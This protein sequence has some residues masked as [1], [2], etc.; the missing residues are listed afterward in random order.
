M[1]PPIRISPN[2]GEESEA[3][4]RTANQSNGP[5]GHQ[6]SLQASNRHPRQHQT[7]HEVAPRVYEMVR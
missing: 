2:K 7:Q 4:W 6:A 1:P 5:A 3:E